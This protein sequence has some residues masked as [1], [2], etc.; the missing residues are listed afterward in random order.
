MLYVFFSN[1]AHPHEE[2]RNP[3]WDSSTYLCFEF[4]P[5]TLFFVR[6]NEYMELV[7]VLNDERLSWPF[8]QRE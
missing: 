6:T 7:Q 1:C 3:S 5:Y 8:V 2:E 4:T